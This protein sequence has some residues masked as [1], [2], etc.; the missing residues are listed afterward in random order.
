GLELVEAAGGVGFAVAAFGVAGL[1][2]AGHPGFDVHHGG[3]FDA[4]VAGA[5]LDDA[6]WEAEALEEEFGV[7]EHLLV[8]LL[9]LFDVVLADDDLLAL[10]ELVDAVEA[11]GVLAVS[12]GFAAEAGADG[13]VLFG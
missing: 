1:F 12:T 9:G 13:G 5:A 7:A 2:A 4:D 8:P 10:V 6:V 3:V 11:G